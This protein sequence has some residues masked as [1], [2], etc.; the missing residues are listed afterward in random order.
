MQL[1]DPNFPTSATNPTLTDKALGVI[2]GLVKLMTFQQIKNLIGITVENVLNSNSAVNA[3]S[4]AQGKVL[5]DEID[6]KCPLVEGKVPS[7]NLPSYVDDVLEYA[8]FASFPVTGEAGKIYVDTSTDFVY[9]WSGSAYFQL[10][11][12]GG[13]SGIRE[14]VT[15]TSGSIVANASVSGTVSISPRYQLLQITT[16]YPCRVRLYT[17]TEK[18]DADITRPIGTDPESNHGLL[19]EFVTTSSLLTADLSP[20]VD[21]FSATSSVAYH[22]T[23]LDT[24]T[25]NLSITLNH[26]KTGA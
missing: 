21:G 25:R 11:S 12:S 8:N 26:V 19:F 9:R 17:S 23:N 6:T 16:N 14:D 1:N 15:F 18:R 3:L 7:A 20:V 2:G 13:G 22:L 4:A 5:K 10:G 24:V